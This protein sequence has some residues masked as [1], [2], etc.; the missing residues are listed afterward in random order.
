[1]HV[2]KRE[3]VMGSLKKMHNEEFYDLYFLLYFVRMIKS[4]EVRCRA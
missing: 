4:R 3:E 1:M 2:S